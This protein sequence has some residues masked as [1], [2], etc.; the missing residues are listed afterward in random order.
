MIFPFPSVAKFFHTK[1]WPKKIWQIIQKQK[2]G[3]S[4][5]KHF[6]KTKY[7]HPTFR[8]SSYLSLL[9]MLWTQDCVG[10]DFLQCFIRLRSCNSSLLVY[11]RYLNTKEYLFQVPILYKKQK[12]VYV[13]SIHT[14]DPCVKCISLTHNFLPDISLSPL[15]TYVCTVGGLNPSLIIYDMHGHAKA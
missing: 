2:E 7:M 1:F 8:F 15:L 6:P 5:V 14:S 13:E 10:P 4:F 12:S 3:S 11:W 9:C